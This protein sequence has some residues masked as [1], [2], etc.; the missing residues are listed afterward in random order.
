MVLPD[1]PALSPLQRRVRTWK[2]IFRPLQTIEERYSQYGDIFRTNTNSKTPFIYFCNPKAIQ[3]IFTADSDTFSSGGS[4]GALQY[5]VG[6]NSLLLQNG[7]RH[8]RQRKLLMPPFHG[9]RMRTY[10][11][12]IYNITSDVIDR[13]QINKPFPIRRSTQEISLKVILG[14]VFGLDRGERYEQLRILLSDVLD[15]IS[16]PL[17]S[18]FLFF[19]FLQKDWGPW[20]P[21]GRFLR[22]RQKVDELIFAEIE[23]AR[24]EANH[25]D[26]ILSLLLEA[27]DEAGDRIS[28]E[29]IKDELLTLLFAGHETTASALAWALYW[30]DK[31]PL[32]REKLLAELATLPANPEK[33]AI[34]KLPY[35]S[36][37]CQE[38][39]R[40]YPIVIT[41]F[42]RVVQKPVEIMGYQLE[43]G[44][45]VLPSIYLTHQ[46][47]DIYPEP[48]KFKP[49]RFLERQFSPYEYLPFGGGSRRCIGSAFALFEMKLV[50]ATI[51][52]KCELK[53][54]SDKSIQPV[55][56]GLTMAPPG[57]MRMVVKHKFGVAE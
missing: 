43:P 42:P 6:R 32:V 7:D 30:I 14:A 48:K 28:D 49:E 11:D 17:T 27:R 31:I 18:T 57:N 19:S 50:L 41:A 54:V 10:G 38:T 52:S 34:T 51:L 53:L 55:R 15:S 2:F 20:S 35:L 37:V 23:T 40:L 33:V 21:W 8:Q 45:V 39:L 13:W 26:D 24:E 29:E 4:N 16:S 5:L 56:R 25:R 47:E 44:M 22:K 46:R 9:D 1:G 36:A 3:Q 12:L